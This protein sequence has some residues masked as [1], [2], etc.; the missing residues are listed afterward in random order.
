[1]DG[2][3]YSRMIAVIR[4]EGGGDASSTPGAGPCRMMLGTVTQ[5]TP[6]KVAVAG[7]TQPSSALRIDA[8][9]TRGA[10]WTASIRGGDIDTDRAELELSESVLNTGDRVL[11]LTSDEQVFYVLS[12]V[13][14]AT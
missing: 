4:D 9:L 8:R 1:M 14:G 7:I 12:K 11:L 3:P 2:N 13:V 5:Q 6:L 10:K